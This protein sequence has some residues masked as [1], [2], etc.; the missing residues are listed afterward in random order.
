MVLVVEQPEWIRV[1]CEA[2]ELL[3][4]GINRGRSAGQRREL[5]VRFADHQHVQVEAR[6]VVA[7]PLRILV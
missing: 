5:Q 2:E 6:G 1:R 7:F 3:L 4:C